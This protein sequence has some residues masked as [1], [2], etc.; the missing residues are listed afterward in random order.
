MPYP[1]PRVKEIDITRKHVCLD[2]ECKKDIYVEIELEHSIEVDELDV[3]VILEILKEEIG[4]DTS[5]ILIGWDID[6]S[7]RI[8]RVLI[9][10]DD[11]AT[12]DSISSRITDVWPRAKR[13]Q[14]VANRHNLSCAPMIVVG[15]MSEI[16]LILFVFVLQ[17]QLL[18]HENEAA[19]NVI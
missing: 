13:A 8:I 18:F 12:G 2:E 15:R 11:E 6:E 16:V 19:D 5:G 17:M 3:D 1:Y 7:G 9:Y 14:V 10:V 4:I